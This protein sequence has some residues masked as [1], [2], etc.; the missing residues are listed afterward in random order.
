ML[1]VIKLRLLRLRDSYIVILIMTAM[2][3][4]L[5]S[6]FG[7]AMS[8]Y[9]P[10]VLIIDEDQSRYSELFVKEITGFG[11]FQFRESDYNNGAAAVEAGDAL[12]AIYIGKG[13]GNQVSEGKEADIGIIKVKDDMDIITLQKLVSDAAVKMMGSN[14]IA[15]ISADFISSFKEG[16][17]R[18]E[19]EDQSYSKVMEYWSSRKPIRVLRSTAGIEENTRN[20]SLKHST[21]GFSLFFSMYAMVFGIGTILYDKQHKTWQRML[22]APVSPSAILGGSMLAAYL[23]GAIQLGVLIIAGKYLLGMDWGNS[24]AGVLLVSGAF[25]FAVTCLGLM[26][27]GIVKTQSQLSAVTP[28]VL[29]STAMLGGCMW[30]L[31][32]VNSKI[33]LFLANLTPQKWAI[34][35]MERIASY[36]QGFEAAVLPSAVLLAMGVVF[37]AVG[38]RLVRIE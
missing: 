22:V 16:V 18:R 21:I 35:G 7:I 25:V 32:I 10:T 3:L 31:E 30:P 14:R 19:L 5:T 23:V 12:T 20:N 28:V 33:I 11:S 17:S 24:T 36:G 38:V 29:T 26:L 4:G 1:T 9:K 6:I 15:S 8:D 13:F 34:Q 27:S 37:F 2:S